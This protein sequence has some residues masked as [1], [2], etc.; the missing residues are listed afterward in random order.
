MTVKNQPVGPAGISGLSWPP[1][2]RQAL[3]FVFDALKRL[4][5]GALVSLRCECEPLDIATDESSDSYLRARQAASQWA[6]VHHVE[7]RSIVDYAAH[8]L[9][10]W[11][12]H[13]QAAE[14]LRLGGRI[15]LSCSED[16][17]A[18]QE[19]LDNN[20]SA[21]NLP[22]PSSETL[23][24]WL[25]QATQLY[26][27]REVAE[28]ADGVQ[29]RTRPD[30]ERFGRWCDWF[31]RRQ[32]SGESTVAISRILRGTTRETVSKQTAF[33]AS[34]LGVALRNASASTSDAGTSPA[35]SIR[36][37]CSERAAR[38]DS[39]FVNATSTALTRRWSRHHCRQA[40][41]S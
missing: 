30:W 28:R 12:R 5:P 33:V 7:C 25:A 38:P 31:V 14:S 8:L 18:E 34:I 36:S 13:P 26:R 17:P 15:H 4:A 35:R 32:V 27:D 10:W 6:R 41:A 2:E 40:A 29:P 24:E 21:Y 39:I 1:A 9:S 22:D 3:D 19:W 37:L 23:E 20:V 16:G 11:A